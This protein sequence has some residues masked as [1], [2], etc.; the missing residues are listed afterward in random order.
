MIIF[1]TVSSFHFSKNHAK[2]PV[3]WYGVRATWTTVRPMNR[4]SH[5]AACRI[6]RS[7]CVYSHALVF[8]VFWKKDTKKHLQSR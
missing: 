8:T 3:W 2:Y 7:G 6:S 1:R 4:E 5:F